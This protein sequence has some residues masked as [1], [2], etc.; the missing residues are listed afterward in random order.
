ML[1]CFIK[2]FNWTFDPDFYNF[3]NLF[4]KPLL[5]WLSRIIFVCSV[6]HV[7][8]GIILLVLWHFWNMILTRGQIK[9]LKHVIT[10]TWCIFSLFLHGICFWISVLRSVRLP[11][12]CSFDGE[13]K[14]KTLINRS[15]L[16]KP[17]VSAKIICL[18]ARTQENRK[19]VAAQK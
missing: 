16:N 14:F 10:W 6:R 7:P 9:R 3:Y 12:I 5:F 2:L 17:E 13:V 15:P 4:A 8:R 19:F 1:I 18:C 11:D